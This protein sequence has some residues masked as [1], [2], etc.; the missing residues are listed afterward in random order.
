MDTQRLKFALIAAVL[1]MLLTS[2]SAETVVISW[3][4]SSQDTNGQSR[5]LPIV[6]HTIYYGTDPAQ[7]ANKLDVAGNAVS[8]SIDIT[9]SGTY[10]FSITATTDSESDRSNLASKVVAAPPVTITELLGTYSLKKG[11]SNVQTG[12]ATYADCKAL[13]ASKATATATKYSCAV[14]NT[15]TVKQ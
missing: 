4:D 10:Y 14:S 3:S 5:T 15:V 1:T 6:K 11:T 2:A 8:Q 7:L 12:L 9:T 13:A